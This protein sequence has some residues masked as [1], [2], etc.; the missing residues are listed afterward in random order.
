MN[1]KNTTILILILTLNLQFS[2]GQELPKADLIY[3]NQLKNWQ[4][5]MTRWKLLNFVPLIGIEELK[6]GTNTFGKNPQNDIIVN[7]EFAPDFIGKIVV[8]KNQLYFLSDS[9][10]TTQLGRIEVDSLYYTFDADHNSQKLHHQFITWY[11]QEVGGT[12]VL[13]FKDDKSPLV[14]N[15]T[16]EEYYPANDDFIVMGQYKKLKT[17]KMER[18]DNVI[19]TWQDHK[20]TGVVQFK[21][22]G[23]K[24]K[25][26]VIN[27]YLVMYTDL[28]NTDTTFP[29]GR[30]I[31]IDTTN[32]D[33][34]IVD[35]NYSFSPPR[36]CSDFTTCD[37][38]PKSNHIPLRIEAGEKY[39]LR[40]KVI[41]QPIH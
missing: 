12:Y 7:S 16:P 37:I 27:D 36:S 31:R 11:V 22:K 20:V 29:L 9:N 28:T 38:P 5:G 39:S 14:Y 25:L 40:D 8:E 33:A 2:W 34:V 30:Y 21:I 26:K 6:E 35:F 3:K 19:G 32:P 24:V 23:K 41:L 13:R 10:S 4:G 15:Y 17:P 1:L 18:L